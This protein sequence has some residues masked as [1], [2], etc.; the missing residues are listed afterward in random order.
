MAHARP[1]YRPGPR[2]RAGHARDLASLL[3]RSGLVLAGPRRRIPAH[4]GELRRWGTTLAGTVA[5]AAARDPDRTALVDDA[6]ALT[7]A[8]LDDRTARLAAGLPLTGPRPR[9]AVLCRNHRGMAETLVACSKRGVE[10]VLLNTGFGGE[11]TRAV[12]GEMRPGLLVADAEFA[13][14][15]AE[16]PV[17]LRRA[18]VWADRPP[19]PGAPT[20]EQIVRAVPRARLDPPPVL[21]RT[22]MLSSGTTGRPKGARRPARPGIRPLASMTSRLPLRTRHTAV[23]EAPLFHTWGYAALQMAWALRCP[24]VLHRRF[25]PE[26]TL[27]AVAAAR[28][29][30]VFAVPVM[31]RR[32][33]DL[34]A[35]VRAAHDA[36]GLRIMALSGGPLP[37]DLATR[38]MDAF[39][40]VVY[41]VYGSTEASWVSI[42]TPRDLRRDPRT[43]GRPPRN[44]T[45]AILDAAGRPVGRSTIG[46]IHAANEMIFE[47][48]TGGD[49]VEVRDGLLATGD[50]GH[51]D[52]R[53]LLFV[54]GRRDGMIVSGGE[55][56]VPR[57]VEDAILRLPGVHEVAVVG[58]PDP[59]WGQRP[60][61]FVVPRPGADLDA[62]TVRAHVQAALARHA[63]PRDVHFLA[64]LPRNA[65][66]KIVPR[67]LTARADGR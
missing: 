6:G 20:L 8:E 60:A 28:E 55:N 42:A 39:G 36:S 14:V 4:L 26:R 2:R 38:F 61:A 65:V 17:A 30:A 66:G 23:I 16:V 40:D 46:H 67:L 63:V 57:D 45:L 44:T 13:P 32:L 19:A 49:P 22:V 37:G 24:V 52:H 33:L 62:D 15:L 48:Y 54:D 64:E 56:V 51:V 21:S 50:L 31:A 12:L 3:L 18:V 35:E 7:F 5:A 59:A 41:N 9:V 47:G 43:A 34:P 11:R 53:G 27:R 10:V 29:A 25:D 1:V 58:V